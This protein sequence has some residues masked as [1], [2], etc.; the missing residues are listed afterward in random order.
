MGR[1]SERA[2]FKVFSWVRFRELFVNGANRADEMAK[3]LC[4]KSLKHAT[5]PEHHATYGV[6]AR[7]CINVAIL[8]HA[9][10][11][12]LQN[13]L[14]RPVGGLEASACLQSQVDLMG[15]IEWKP[16]CSLRASLTPRR[17]VCGAAQYVHESLELNRLV[18]VFPAVPPTDIGSTIHGR[19]P[20]QC[21]R[22]P[23]TESRPTSPH[24]PAWVTNLI[25]R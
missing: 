24:S 14:G 20:I 10:T 3:P 16:S 12:H 22:K 7:T 15:S 11:Q 13:V 1:K 8:S 6:R 9:G 19:G 4:I 25:L 23:H 21:A 17:L 5:S 2:Q 18:Y